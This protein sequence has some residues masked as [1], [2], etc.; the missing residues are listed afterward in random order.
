MAIVAKL[1]TSTRTETVAGIHSYTL[2]AVCRG[3]ENKDWAAA[4]PAAS[5]TISG[6]DIDEAWDAAG[7][8]PVELLAYF[9][10]DDHGDWDLESCAFS[11]GGCQ[12]ALRCARGD[13]R[14]NGHKATMTINASAA[15][16]AMR[17]A[18][19]AGLQAGKP[20]AFSVIV[21]PVS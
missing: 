6:P 18:F 20:P 21:G 7:A 13:D 9:Q 11:Y 17:D 3:E 2:S 12:V 10:P 15:T 1:Y 16:Q 5:L 19:I 8:Q 14:F 4:T